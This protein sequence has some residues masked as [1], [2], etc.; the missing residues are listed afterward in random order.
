LAKILLVE[1]DT[2]LANNIREWLSHQNHTVETIHDGGEAINMLKTYRY[3]AI[4]LDWGLPGATGIDV[5]KAFRGAGGKTPVLFLTGKDQTEDKEFGLDAGADDYLTKP[6]HIKE[7]SARVRALLRRPPDEEPE[8][9]KF[10]SIEINMAQ[11]LVSKDG[12]P[13]KLM[14]KE[15]ALLEFLARH[16]NTTFSA[17]ALI[18]RVWPADNEIDP[19]SVR[20]YVTRLRSRLD[21]K[22]QSIIETVHKEGY[23]LVM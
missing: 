4:V 7:L 8:A 19:L 3:D 21:D 16:P 15:Y 18:E 22:E 2:L 1:D 12:K 5:L 13:I 9:I 20:T 14:R 10:G 6:F 11:H 17:E 23:K